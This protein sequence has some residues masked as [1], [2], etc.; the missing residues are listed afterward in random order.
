MRKIL[1]VG[2]T[3]SFVKEFVEILD[4]SIYNIDLMTYRN[5]S[6]VD[7]THEWIFMDIESIDSVNNFLDKISNNIYDMILITIGNSMG[8][9][10]TDCTYEESL[11]F[12]NNYLVNYI[13]LV[14]ELIK[15]LTDDGKIISISSV[16]AH[17]PIPDVHYSAVK[18]GVEAGLRSMSTHLK[19]QQ[20]IV[21]IAPSLID[22]TKAMLDL[23]KEVLDDYFT[24]G[25]RPLITR[26]QVAEAILSVKSEMNG[27]IVEI[28]SD[29]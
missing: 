5:S 21:S 27:S 9:N 7:K 28:F 24:K 20:C 12:Y 23:P 11:R 14:S 29:I 6:K 25:G 4:T 19:K 17:K 15:N 16:A 13:F 26:M 18:A 2:G 3:A 22:N 1:V 8:K 10:F